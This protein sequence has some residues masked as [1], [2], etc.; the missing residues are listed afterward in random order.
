MINTAAERQRRTLSFSLF[1][2]SLSLSSSS[3]SVA[4]AYMSRDSANILASVTAKDT[5][6]RD[7]AQFVEKQTMLCPFSLQNTFLRGLILRGLCDAPS[8]NRLSRT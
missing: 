5:I 3:G 2:L 1:I 4:A 6:T 8:I 7:D